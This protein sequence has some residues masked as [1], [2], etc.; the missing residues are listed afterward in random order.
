MIIQLSPYHPS[1]GVETLA[2][3]RDGSTL[4]INGE[5]ITLSDLADIA[6][7]QEPAW[8]AHVSGYSDG[9][10]TVRLAYPEGASEAVRFPA[11]IIDPPDG[12]IPLPE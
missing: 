6:A 5:P 11:P 8:P 1:A 10:I 3:E 4:I 2:L 9:T 12:P 7:Q